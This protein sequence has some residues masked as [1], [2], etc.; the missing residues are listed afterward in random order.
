MGQ[1]KLPAR[2]TVPLSVLNQPLKNKSV[3]TTPIKGSLN[4]NLSSLGRNIILTTMPAGTKLIAGNKPVSFVTAQQ[5]QQLQQQGQ[6]TQVR[7]Q[8]VQT[9]QLQQHVAT[10]SPKSVS[11][12]VVTTAPSQKNAPDPPPAHQ[13]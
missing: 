3:V 7:I 6:A 1:G 9:Q 13:Q 4:T 8:T 10:G 11:A 2:I 12:V 5:F